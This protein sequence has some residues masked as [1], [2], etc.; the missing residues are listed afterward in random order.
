MS[1]LMGP[2][3]S[4]PPPMGPAG[5]HFVNMSVDK[6]RWGFKSCVWVETLSL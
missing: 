5:T 4:S 1:F 2:E 6:W 3:W